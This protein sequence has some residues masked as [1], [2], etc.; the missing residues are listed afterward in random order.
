MYILPQKEILL[1]MTLSEVLT[2]LKAQ[3]KIYHQ[4]GM[5]QSYFSDMIKRIENGMCRTKTVNNFL[6]KF[7]YTVEINEIWKRSNSNLE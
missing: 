7:G 3:K 4:V 2:E 6:L 1:Y 5:K